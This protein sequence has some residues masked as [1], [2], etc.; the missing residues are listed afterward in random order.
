MS[1]QNAAQKDRTPDWDMS[2]YF[3]EMDGNVY[4]TFRHTLDADVSVLLKH[5]RRLG[6]IEHAQ[7]PVWI[8]LLQKLEEITARTGHL[9]SYLGCMGAADAGNETIQ[10]ETAAAKAARAELVK[11]FVVIRA[12]L[13]EA[14]EDVFAAL[15]NAPELNEATYFIGRLRKSASWSMEPELEALAAD[16]DATGLSAWGRLYDQV[17]GTLEFDL[18]VPGQETRRLPVA[19]T[20]S[21]LEDADPAVRKAA[22]GGA[23][24]AWEQ[25]SSVTAACLNAIAGA[26]LTLYKRRGIAHFLEPAL[27]DAGI[28]H[29]TLD[30]IMAVAAARKAVAQRYL[31]RKAQLLGREKLGFQDLM[32]PLPLTH[33][34]RVNW[35]EARTRVLSAFESFYPDLARFTEM[36][37]EQNWIDYSPRLGKR[38]GGFCSTSSIIRQSRILMTYNETVGDISTLAHELSHAF[39]GWLMRDMRPWS[40]RYP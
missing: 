29:K 13:K 39:H 37:F 24:R 25:T 21:L 15:L 34:E 8:D 23:N 27:F 31:Q 32:A 36:A 40:L 18:V 3:P 7:L 14:D 5:V 33:S 26:R 10:G 6:K 19:M 2:P 28:S 4:R 38:P 20:R 35:A 1:D 11:I 30:T 12:A 9:S 22:L 16:L 17:S